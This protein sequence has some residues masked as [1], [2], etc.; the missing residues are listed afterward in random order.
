M[1]V[2]ISLGPKPV[3]F[4]VR[5]WSVWGV[6]CCKLIWCGLLYVVLSIVL[7]YII[8]YYIMSYYELY[9]FLVFCFVKLVLDFKTFNSAAVL[10]CVI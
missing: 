5:I 2:S 6:V 9:C 7:Y 8:L 3:L 10:Y 4:G 1:P